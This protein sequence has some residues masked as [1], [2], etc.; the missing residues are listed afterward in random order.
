MAL[1]RRT[2]RSAPHFS[3][4][5]LELLAH[6]PRRREIIAGE[7][8]VSTMPSREHQRVCFQVA[9]P[10]DAWNRTTG[11]GEVYLA[12]GVIFASDDDVAPDVVWISAERSDGGWDSAGHLR[13]APELVVEVLS[14]GAT[15]ERRD[16]EAKLTLYARRGVDEYW[17]VDWRHRVVDV[18]RRD[19]EALL[20]T[21]RLREDDNVTSPLLPG[22]SA[23]VADVFRGLPPL[24]PRR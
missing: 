21:S 13:R 5:D 14:P 10:L 16:R 4:E 8:Y 2:A 24:A 23:P 7:M 17:I 20:Q 15:N 9:V 12:P 22:F 3:S 18:F 19:G 11:R 6:D 1:T